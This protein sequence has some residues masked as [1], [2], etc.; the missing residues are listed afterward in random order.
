MSSLPTPPFSP[1]QSHLPPSDGSLHSTLNLLD[2]LEDFYTNQRRW[3]DHTRIAL[4]RAFDESEAV[5]TDSS[6]SSVRSD[7]EQRS[8]SP[9]NR[10]R[11]KKGLHLKLELLNSPPSHKH[12]R[13]I[14]SRR[15]L[16]QRKQ[17]LEML[18]EIAQARI[19]SCR[20]VRR[21]N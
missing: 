9:D 15:D 7:D 10:V 11:R 13:R 2:S 6:S 17:M 8:A 12:I 21:I 14:T 1:V 5:H 20:F 19:D 3:I 4:D 16:D 18:D